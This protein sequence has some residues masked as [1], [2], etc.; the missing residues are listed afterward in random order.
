MLYS[1]T[2][3]VALRATLY[4][5]LQT[6]GKLFPVRQ[7]AQATGLSGPYLAKIMH[8][9]IRAGL[10]RAHRGPGG[11]LELGRP[12]GE[13]SLWS[14]VLAMDGTVE[15]EWCVLRL[16]NC[17]EQKPCPLHQQWYP[18]RA[19]M[20]SLLEETTLASLTQLSR[21]PSGLVRESQGEELSAVN[22]AGPVEAVPSKR[23]EKRQ[24][25]RGK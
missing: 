4:L 14:V 3:G 7:I 15:S 22:P 16:Q 21:T 5:A 2:S 17:S 19:A 18:L 25:R 1:H 8:R 11:G 6:P 24:A 20:Q 9:L 13:I 12:P 23:G 10:V